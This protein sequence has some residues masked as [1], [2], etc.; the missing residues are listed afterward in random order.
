M[1]EFWLIIRKLTARK[2]L[3]AAARSAAVALSRMTGRYVNIGMPWSYSIEPCDICNLKCKECVSGLGVIRRRRGRIDMDEYRMAVDSIA[4]YAMNLFLYFQGEPTL[5]KDFA[6]MARYAHEKGIFTATSTNGHYLDTQTS[7]RIVASGIDKIIVSLDGYDQET[8]SSY[9]VG[10]DFAQV[11][12]GIRTL[13]DAK[14][15]LNSQTPIIEAQ[16]LVTKINEKGLDAVRKIAL[17]AGADRHVLKTMQI[18]NDED[19]ETFKTTIDRYSRYDDQNR[20]KNPVGFCKRIINSAVI[21][22]DMDVLPCCYDKDASLKLGNLR[23]SPLRK[24]LKSPQ[25]RKIISTIESDRA[26]RPAICQNCGG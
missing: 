22:I 17:E 11:V 21:T 19:F 1:K 6:E 10:G 15:R 14:R 13:A 12:T 24:I 18:E 2:A 5:H 4:P 23:E 20:L 16:T 7:E 26:S 8:Y 25:A 3:N 9:R